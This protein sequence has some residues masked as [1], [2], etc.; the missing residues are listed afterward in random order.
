MSGSAR[1]AEAPPAAAREALVDAFTDQQISDLLEVFGYT[2]RVVD[3]GSIT[4]ELGA[5]RVM[6]F[7]HWDGD[8]QLYYVMTGGS[9][10]HRAVNDWN[11]TRRHSRAYIDSEGDLVLE[12][13][14]LSLGG[15]TERQFASFVM[16]YEKT[17]ELFV[18]EIVGPGIGLPAPDRSEA[19]TEAPSP[20]TRWH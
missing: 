18:V 11:R 2:P 14:L 12:S 19:P 13:D 17:L 10:D 20:P 5:A 8:L 1:E 3:D 4:F 16:L 7:N 15:M 6:M 9:W